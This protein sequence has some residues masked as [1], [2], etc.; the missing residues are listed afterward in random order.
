LISAW[1][2]ASD[3]V[4]GIAGWSKARRGRRQA[5]LACSRRGPRSAWP[6]PFADPV[7]VLDFA[8]FGAFMM[9]AIYVRHAH[10][11][12]VSTLEFAHEADQRVDSRER[13]GM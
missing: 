7:D 5:R 1:I 6:H 9:R 3:G 8:D 11:S 2:F 4:D 10:P 12:C 13:H